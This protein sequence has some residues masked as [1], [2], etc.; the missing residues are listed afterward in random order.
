MVGNFRPRFIEIEP[1][2]E[3]LES[4]MV[5]MAGLIHD[6]TGPLEATRGLLA[7]GIARSFRTQTDPEGNPWVAWSA[8]YEPRA[9]REIES[10]VHLGQILERSLRLRDTATSEY[11]F[12]VSYD[13]VFF[14]WEALPEYG[15]LHQF[16]GM[17]GKGANVPARAY[18][19]IDELDQ[20]R[21][22]GLFESYID[23]VLGGMTSRGR[24][25]LGR[26]I[27]LKGL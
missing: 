3:I 21:I 11:A 1:D 15:V 22:T 26:F 6:M 2:P 18:V 7:A 23:Y 10:G 8:S 27:S 16:G 12:F 14:S 25:A 4:Q 20:A 5:E 9:L 24:G 17:A 19:G 13:S